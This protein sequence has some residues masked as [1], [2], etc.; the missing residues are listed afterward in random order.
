MAGAATSERGQDR[1]Q[2]RL[3]STLGGEGVM[4]IAPWPFLES[5]TRR[6]DAKPSFCLPP[7]FAPTFPLLYPHA[8]EQ[9]KEQFYTTL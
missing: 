4:V 7:P 1:T 9:H 3:G 5:A 2:R 6:R 8:T